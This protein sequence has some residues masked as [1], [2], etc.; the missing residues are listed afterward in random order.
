MEQRPPRDHRARFV[1]PPS[2]VTVTVIGDGRPSPARGVGLAVI[3]VAA[4]ATIAIVVTSS[5]PHAA[6]R[7]IASRPPR[8]RAASA[9]TQS[10]AGIDA[11]AALFRNSL[12][13]MTLTFAPSEPSYFS[14]TPRR[15]CSTHRGAARVEVFHQV[16][17]QV[18]LVLNGDGQACAGAPIPDLVQVELAVCRGSATSLYSRGVAPTIVMHRAAASIAHLG[19]PTRYPAASASPAP[20]VSTTSTAGAG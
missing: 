16:G 10:P 9:T 4:L 2:E 5:G 12:Q 17:N 18:R 15:V 3:A 13:C 7:H 19:P 14:A 11:I 1:D 8:V 20:V 6:S